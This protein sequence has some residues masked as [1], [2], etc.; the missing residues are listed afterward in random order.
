MHVFCRRC[1]RRQVT[2]E[3]TA[4]NLAKCP[5]CKAAYSHRNLRENKKFTNILD[6]I[7]EF[8]EEANVCTQIPA[9]FPAFDPFVAKARLLEQQKERS[10][11]SEESKS[12]DDLGKLARIA[13]DD[14]SNSDLSSLN[15]IDTAQAFMNQKSLK[16]S[17]TLKSHQS[18][19]SVKS[20][21]SGKSKKE[22]KDKISENSTKNEV[23]QI[24]E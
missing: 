8:R 1:V 4:Q 15:D 17:N 3:K 16:A 13:E 2:T 20:E 14:E 12:K 7:K 10:K 6:I 23:P 11:S 24:E 21:K 19:K 22:P 5:E 18:K 9:H